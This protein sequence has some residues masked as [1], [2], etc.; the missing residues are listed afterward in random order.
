MFPRISKFRGIRCARK[1]IPQSGSP[2]IS[3][4]DAN[5][6]GMPALNRT[7]NNTASSQITRALWLS[8]S[9][10]DGFYVY[11]GG[12]VQMRSE[13]V[14]NEATEWRR[15]SYRQCPHVDMSSVWIPS[16][17]PCKLSSGPLNAMQLISH[18]ASR[19]C[20][21]PFDCYKVGRGLGK[22]LAL[23]LEGTRSSI[24]ACLWHG[25]QMIHTRPTRA[26]LR[27]SLWNQQMSSFTVYSEYNRYP[28]IRRARTH[29]K[30]SCGSP[31]NI[32]QYKASAEEAEA[33]RR[34]S[35]GEGKHSQ[36]SECSLTRKHPPSASV[37]F[38]QRET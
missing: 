25:G 21:L 3:F 28:L 14:L 1:I 4:S 15:N 36:W 32:E 33:E 22:C 17:P 7:P 35:G 10:R 13:S 37:F 20:N 31:R 5:R 27:A 8:E 34:S 23:G 11:M 38:R 6:S 24:H 30:P 29:A 26:S 18:F 2:C 16:V 12:R 9:V 19:S